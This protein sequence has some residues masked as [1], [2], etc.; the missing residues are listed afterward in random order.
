[1]GLAYAVKKGEIEAPSPEIQ[2]KADSMT[3][4]E[5]KKKAEGKHKNLPVKIEEEVEE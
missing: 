1:M 4:E 3:M 5:L 2:K